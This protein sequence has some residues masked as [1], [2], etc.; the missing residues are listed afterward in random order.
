[1]DQF[2]VN[3]LIREVTQQVLETNRA[4]ISEQFSQQIKT[5]SSEKDLDVNN[6]TALLIGHVAGTIISMSVELASAVT[7]VTLHK[8]GLIVPVENQEIPI[9]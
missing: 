2:D 5:L 1:M 9:D 6:D 3:H 7:A 4:N 8:L